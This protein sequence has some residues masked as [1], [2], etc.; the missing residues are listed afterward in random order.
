[1]S[2]P[3]SS[4]F[5]FTLDR[6][7]RVPT[8]IERRGKIGQ[9]SRMEYRLPSLYIGQQTNFTQFRGNVLTTL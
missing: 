8:Y 6:K 9:R 4:F 1:M 5:F 3:V 7:M 2:H